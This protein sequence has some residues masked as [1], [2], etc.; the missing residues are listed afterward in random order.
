MSVE[1]D[2]QLAIRI[3]EDAYR[4]HLQSGNYIVVMET[5][6]RPMW[7]AT[8]FHDQVGLRRSPLAAWIRRE[9]SGLPH[10]IRDPLLYVGVFNMAS[11]YWMIPEEEWPQGQDVSVAPVRQLSRPFSR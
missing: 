1:A 4:Q 8:P 5:R 6:L 2:R 10:D 3:A 9:V 11:D 7:A